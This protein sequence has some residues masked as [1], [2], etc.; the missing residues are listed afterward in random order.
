[1]RAALALGERGRGRTAPNPHVGCILVQ[2]GVVVG[3]GWTAPGGRPHAEAAAL[4]QAGDGARGATAYTT[5]EPCAHE[6]ARGP[7]CAASLAEAGVT[8]VVAALTDPDPRTAGRGFAHLREAGVEVVTGVLEAE[9]KRAHAGFI[10]RVTR[11]RPRVT[12]KLAQTIDGRIATASG[13]SRW[14]TGPEARRHVHWERAHTDAI[15]VGRGTFEADAPRLDVRIEGL[16]DRSPRRVLLTSGEALEGWTT[17]PSPEAIGTLHDVNDLFVEG[18]AETATAFLSADLV[19]RLL[20]YTAPILV[21]GGKPAIG[22]L[23]LSALADAHGRWTPSGSR[24]LGPDRLD[25]YERLRD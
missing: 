25:I 1:M 10:S 20:I 14:I 23:G 6:S 18:G 4:A 2:G 24:V 16:E 11:G 17:L 5:L 3:R 15:L 19:D 9:A 13:E 22:D 12:L 7:T 8:R 21:G